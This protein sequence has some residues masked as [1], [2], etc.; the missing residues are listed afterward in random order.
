MAQPQNTAET[1]EKFMKAGRA[2]LGTTLFLLPLFFWL[3]THDQFELP[4]LLLLRFFSLGMLACLILAQVTSPVLR[5][6]RSPLDWPLLAWSLWLLAKTFFSVCPWVSWR[7]E[8]ENF[9]GS[10][11]QL[12]YSLLFW[13]TLQ[14]VHNL[15][16]ARRL[17]HAFEASAYAVACYAL[18]QALKMDFVAWSSTSV[19]DGRYFA[20]MGNPMFL[21]ALMVM[22]L[23]LLMARALF[24]HYSPS[25]R[26]LWLHWGGLL[27]C[28]L[29]WFVIHISSDPGQKF[30]LSTLKAKA[31]PGAFW[32]SLVLLSGLVS[33]AALIKK[34]WREGAAWLLNALQGAVLFKALADTGTRGAFAGLLAVG[35]FFIALGLRRYNLKLRTQGLALNKRLALLGAGTAGIFALMV[36]VSFALGPQFRSRMLHTLAHPMQAFDE[37][38]LQIWGP[39]LQ[40][41]WAYPL[42]GTGVDTFKTVFL[43]FQKS[44]FN[45]FEG[46]NVASRTAHCEP[47]QILATLGLIGLLLWS[48]L[49]FLWGLTLWRQS[50]LNVE[51]R[52]PLLLGLMALGLGYLVQNLVSFGVSAITAPFFVCLALTFAGLSPEFRWR[53]ASWVKPLLWLGLLMLSWPGLSALRTARADT[54]C[55]FGN[56]VNSRLPALERAELNDCRGDAANA[57]DA[58]K[59]EGFELSE[60]AKA[61]MALWHSRLIDLE[62]RPRAT[63]DEA[64]PL[65]A[66][67][68]QAAQSLLLLLSSLKQEKGVALAPREVKY[69]VCLGRAYEELFKRSPHPEARE[70][71]FQR[72]ENAYARCTQLNPRHAYYRGNLARLYS[73][74]AALGV[75][76]YF[77]KAEASYKEAI[78]LGPVTALFYENLLL[79]YGDHNRLEKAIDLLKPLEA[80]EQSLAARLY[81]QAGTAYWQ[82]A[83]SLPPKSDEKKSAALQATAATFL[84]RAQELDPENPDLLYMQA[85]LAFNAGDKK[86]A[87]S[88]VDQALKLKP[89]H[90]NSLRLKAALV[91][92]PG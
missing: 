73:H 7:G 87:R 31:Q 41:A 48:W 36:A 51:E 59:N 32:L 46:E 35:G 56:R 1:P 12:N 23:S 85:A 27:A 11:T 71:W 92:W 49:I 61:E 20:S 89:T 58:I 10:L 65:K 66:P 25:S 38:R 78:A 77:E 84:T 76:G 33:A 52:R 81:S 67:Y 15:D 16:Q 42:T 50:K 43:Q 54:C 79:L 26:A 44:K 39:A 37:S 90:E 57:L 19:G 70:R 4:K 21:G 24:E 86:R 3:G 55:S 62:G 69:W 9:A 28:L 5:L 18:F 47:L 40:I 64:A 91:Q 13:L 34:G 22:A 53:K 82:T 88:L 60:E 72:C 63:P 8:Y 6:R 83:A 80:E 29:I 75:P 30:S 74:K 17:L 45:R 2:L 14:L 68:T